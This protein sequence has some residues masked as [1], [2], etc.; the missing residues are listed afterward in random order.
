[1]ASPVKVGRPGISLASTGRREIV[2]TVGAVAA[3]VGAAYWARYVSI[4]GPVLVWF[5]P[6]GVA[7]GVLYLRPRLFPLLVVAEIISTAWIMRLADEY[8]PLAL[9]VNA[10]VIVG[11]YQ[12]AGVALR[13]LR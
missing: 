9:V 11:A 2:F 12:L 10:L 5:P 3:Y 1:M 6:A 13:R 8:G 4:P 7:I